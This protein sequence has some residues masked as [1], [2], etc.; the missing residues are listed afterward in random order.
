MCTR[1]FG[2]SLA[3]VVLVSSGWG[4]DG[5]TSELQVWLASEITKEICDADEPERS[6]PGP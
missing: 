1:G 6:S 4:D 3:G 5:G 2:P